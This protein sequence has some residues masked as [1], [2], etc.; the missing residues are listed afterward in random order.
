MPSFRER[1]GFVRPLLLDAA[2]GTELQRRGLDTT[3]PLWS[4]RALLDSP[5][6][7]AAIHRE[8]AGAGADVLTANT[9]RTHRRTLEKEGLGER[10]VE[11]TALAVGL[12]RAAAKGSG[13]EIYVAGSLSPLEDC[14]R[15]DRVPDDAALDREHREQAESLAAAGADVLLLETHNTVR[16]LA[17]AARAAKATGLPVVASMVTDG[18]GRLLSGEP[19]ESAVRALAVLEPDA[20]SINC[21]PAR[22]LAFDLSRL[23]AA[24]PEVPLGA[25]GNLGLPEDESGWSFT[26]SLSPEAYA[27]CAK[28]WLGTGARI[29]GG[30]CGTTPAHT[31]AL[32]GII[33]QETSIASP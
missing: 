29:V 10:A 15:P 20:L 16:E 12:A 11:L 4:A 18:T 9:F 3:L 17:A 27:D 25:W 22:R 28:R 24:A 30:C 7:V 8:E 13:R 1:L 33:G 32:R 26:D 23:S 14:Y 5:E 6:A 2:M 31:I 19:I 21:V